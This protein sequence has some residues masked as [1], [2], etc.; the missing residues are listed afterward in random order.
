MQQTQKRWW[1]N[2]GISYTLL[3]L[4]F[5]TG[6]CTG[7]GSGSDEG[8]GAGSGF[9]KDP[10]KDPDPVGW[11]KAENKEDPDPIVPH[12]NVSFL[13]AIF[14]FKHCF[15]EDP[16][17]IEVGNSVQGS[18][19]GQPGSDRQGQ[20]SGSD[21]KSTGSGTLVIAL[22]LFVQPVTNSNGINHF[23]FSCCSLKLFD[24]LHFGLFTV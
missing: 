11:P 18:G 3:L 6:Q 7:S 8:S 10:I 1:Q 21:R 24:F 15:T 20:G 4:L 5:T 2:T 12:E 19:S 22:V 14:T 23:N 13:D 9:L 16:D 17:P